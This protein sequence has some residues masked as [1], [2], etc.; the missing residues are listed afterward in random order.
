MNKIT[1]QLAIG[2]R[3]ARWQ[4]YFIA[5]F[6]PLSLLISLLTGHNSPYAP[7]TVTL[8]LLT[9]AAFASLIW[10][11]AKDGPHGPLAVMTGLILCGLALLVIAWKVTYRPQ[12]VVS[13]S[14][15]FGKG[16]IGISMVAEHEGAENMDVIAASR[17]P[18]AGYRIARL[19]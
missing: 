6:L 13:V 5:A 15:R 18:L 17:N 16:S 19:A 7:N 8:M 2:W 11:G 3:N 14:F 1:K 12:P 4:W 9:L 10:A